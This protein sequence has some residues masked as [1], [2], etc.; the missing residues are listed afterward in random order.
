MGAYCPTPLLDAD[1]LG[2]IESNIL[3]PT[4]DALRRDGIEYRGVLYAGVMLTPGGPKVLEF[5]CRFGDPECQPLMVRLRSDLIELCWATC[6]G[7]LDQVA[8]IDFDSRTACCVV[9]C[10]GGYPGPF[11]R[12]HVI[13]GI[14]DA[15]ATGDVIV[16]QAGTKRGEGGAIVTD[17]GRV[18]G[19]TALAE[20]LQAARDLANAAAEKIHFEGAYYRRDIGGRVLEEATKRLSD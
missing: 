18:L 4:I 20:D 5:N 19:V 14:D 8:E 17:G 11:Q 7:S 3:V 16:F 1:M 15:E 2:T 10:S 6:T 12:G 9:M 13:S